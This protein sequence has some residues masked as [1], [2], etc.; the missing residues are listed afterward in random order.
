MA[1]NYRETLSRVSRQAPLRVLHVVGCMNRG[2]VETWLMHVLRHSDATRIRHEFLVHTRTPGLYD[3]EIRDLRSDLISVPWTRTPPM[4][5]VCLRRHLRRRGP[6]DVVH[7][8]VHHYS[9]LVLRAAWREKVP[10][11]V[12]HSHNDTRQ[13]EGRAGALR[14]SYVKLMKRWL[15]RYTTDRLAVSRESAMAL[16]GTGGLT[17]ERWTI[18]CYGHDFSPFQTRP[19]RGAVRAALGLNP[20]TIVVGH[21]GRFDV[22]K[23]HTFLLRVAAELARLRPNVKLLLVGDGPLKK[24]IERR[25]IA[26]RLQHIVAF[27]GLRADVP[28]LL[29]GAMDVF[30]FPSLYEGLPLACTEAQAAG[31]PLIISDSITPDVDVVPGLVRRLPTSA[32]PQQWAADC[33]TAASS[34]RV[35]PA[36]AVALLKQSQFN[37]SSCVTKLEAV[38]RHRSTPLTLTGS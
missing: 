14:H 2:G 9:G 5:S 6:Y 28:T 22:Q 11:R 24:A 31:L 1:R 27:T 33:L 17:N 13:S 19:D 36:R 8:H 21:V 38:Y 3:A 12:A 16:A 35:D 7:S 25:S 10:C 4:Y 26:S 34:P 23:N 15:T 32:S 30:V 18:L 29:M 37:I 20:D